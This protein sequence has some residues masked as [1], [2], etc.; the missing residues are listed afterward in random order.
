[1]YLGTRQLVAVG[2]SFAIS[3][4]IVIGEMHGDHYHQEPVMYPA[5]IHLTVSGV[6]S[7]STHL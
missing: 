4:S 6:S 2:V 5:T 1:M 7:S 3:V